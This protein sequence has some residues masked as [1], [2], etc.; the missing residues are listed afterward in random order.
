MNQPQQRESAASQN[1]SQARRERRLMLRTR[2]A[3]RA[4][5]RPIHE[6]QAFLEE[7]CNTINIS[8]GG[9]YFACDHGSYRMHMHLYVSCPDSN[10]ALDRGGEMARVVRVDAL[11][12]G[13]WGIAVNYLHSTGFHRA[14]QRN[15]SADAKGIRP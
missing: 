14:P 13:E 11:P 8:R 12:G 9:I 7:V 15:A 2:I 4:R 6:A 3:C 10:S 5:I 1:I